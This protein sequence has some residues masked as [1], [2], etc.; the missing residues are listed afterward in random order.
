[1]GIHTGLRSLALWSVRVQIPPLALKT[2]KVV[3]LGR[4]I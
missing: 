3:F 2:E 4:K 1:M